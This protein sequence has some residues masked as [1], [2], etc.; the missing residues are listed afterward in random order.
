MAIS[1]NDLDIAANATSIS[2]NS[3]AISSNDTD[4]AANATSI[5]TNATNISSNDSDISTN[6]SGIST[7]A[8]GIATNA[9]N[10]S[11]NDSDI[12]A[13]VTAIAAK[14][15]K[16]NAVF[17][18]TF[19]LPNNVITQ[20]Y[21]AVDSIKPE[22]LNSAATP[23]GG[24][25]VKIKSDDSTA[26]EYG[27]CG[28][29]TIPTCAAGEYLGTRA[30][31]T[32]LE[33]LTG[34]SW[35]AE[36]F[37]VT[38]GGS[39]DQHAEIQA[40]IDAV[41]AAGGG[42]LYI[43]GDVEI[44]EDL[45]MKSNVTLDGRN[46]GKLKAISGGSFACNSMIIPNPDASVEFCV[47]T[48]INVGVVNLELDLNSQAKSGFKG[49]MSTAGRN[50]VS[51]V[52]NYVHGGN[53][54]QDATNIYL[55]VI[56]TGHSIVRDN[57][58]KGAGYRDAWNNA[59]KEKGIY[60]NGNGVVENNTISDVDD[61]GIH[62]AGVN[63]SVIN[64]TVTNTNKALNTGISGEGLISGNYVNMNYPAQA[65]NSCSDSTECIGIKLTG[66]NAARASDN[67]VVVT[68]DSYGMVLN[69]TGYCFRKQSFYDRKYRS[70]DSSGVC[71]GCP[72]WLHVQ[73]LF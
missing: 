67:Y 63:S 48:A 54:V 46:V 49:W 62:S 20:A 73:Q 34:S 23:S 13:N 51:L 65:S 38:Y 29:S 50:G 25:C 43:S 56:S 57:T 41:N 40:G 45:L 55:S 9:S 30:G 21:M 3:S 17:T 18:G 69:T 24:Q 33:C 53:G 44:D 2:I 31:S 26:F 39:G 16:N 36:D 7:N 11:S 60:L 42:V 61:I 72:I 70:W 14:A 8:S 19:G 71:A 4:I 59:A 68:G 1:S 28:G 35:D 37:G 66:A 27:A 32:T 52:N 58:I 5:S 64:N 15:P 6:A 22:Q 10:I 47:S 12:A